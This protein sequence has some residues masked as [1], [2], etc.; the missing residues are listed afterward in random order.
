MSLLIVDGLSTDLYTAY[1]EGSGNEAWLLLSIM[2]F[3]MS[4]EFSAVEDEGSKGRR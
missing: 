4:M 3:G 1:D 2:R